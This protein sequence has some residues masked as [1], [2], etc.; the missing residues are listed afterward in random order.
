MADPE[1]PERE[2]EEAEPEVSPDFDFGAFPDLSG[3]SDPGYAGGFPSPEIPGYAPTRDPE[4]PMYSWLEGSTPA[5]ATVPVNSAQTIADGLGGLFGYGPT[6]GSRTYGE[7]LPDNQRFG[8]A[9]KN[10][11]AGE[12][13]V[14]A[15]RAMLEGSGGGMLGQGLRGAFESFQRAVDRPDVMDNPGMKES[16][17]GL[18][19]GDGRDLDRGKVLDNMESG[20]LT[21]VYPEKAFDKDGKEVGVDRIYEYGDG[22]RF[23]REPYY[24]PPK[25]EAKPAARGGRTTAT[26]TTTTTTSPGG[27]TADSSNGAY[28][29][30]EMNKDGKGGRVIGLGGESTQFSTEEGRQR[31][32]A[33]VA[34]ENSR[35]SKGNQAASTDYNA[36]SAGG[37]GQETFD[38]ATNYVPGEASAPRGQE[39]YDSGYR[40]SPVRPSETVDSDGI[41]TNIATGRIVGHIG[42]DGRRYDGPPSIQ[43]RLPFGPYSGT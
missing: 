12:N 31:A 2:E 16:L 14:P 17:K 29:T 10:W 28:F 27:S 11:E 22:K 38:P 37:R 34:S 41:I 21:R 39:I 32:I 36:R 42:A 33:W 5:P 13:P 7:G 26:T 3:A 35:I 8:D 40:A 1:A 9:S 43:S 20:Y 30:V 19:T 18:F 24:R 15:L 25:E 23:V 4:A 6:P